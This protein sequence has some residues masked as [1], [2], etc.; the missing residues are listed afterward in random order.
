M[1]IQH[2]Q[3]GTKGIFYEAGKD[4]NL[5]KPDHTMRDD[6]LL[7]ISHTEVDD[8]LRRQNIGKELVNTAGEYARKTS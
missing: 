3:S 2:S 6:Q 8:S 5:A 7:A 1:T 4:D